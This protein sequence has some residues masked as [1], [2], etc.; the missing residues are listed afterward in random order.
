MIT[1]GR[2]ASCVLTLDDPALSRTHCQF[3]VVQD[4]V[5]VRDLNSRNGTLLDGESVARARLEPGDVLTIGTTAIG[6]EGLEEVPEETLGRRTQAIWKEV[7]RTRD[8]PDAQDPRWKQLLPL[9][10]K[11]LAELDE[12]VVLA[13]IIDGA[14]DLVGAERG[15]LLLFSGDEVTVEVART[16]WRRDIDD[17][18]VEISRGIALAVRDAD[19]GVLI[20]DAGEDARVGG[21][22]SVADLSLRSV[23]CVPLRFEGHIGGVAY[24]DHRLRP[25]RFGETDLELMEAFADLAAVALVTSGRYRDVRRKKESLEEEVRLERARLAAARAA[26]DVRGRSLEER[27]RHEGIVARSESM[28]RLLVQCERVV[29]TELPVLLVGE[30]GTGRERLARILHAGGPRR[31]GAFVAVGCASLPEALAEVELFGHAEGA[32]TGASEARPGLFERA[33]EGT[34]FLDGVEDLGLGTQAALLRVLETGEAR[35]VGEDLAREVGA[36]IIATTRE[37]PDA[38]VRDGRLRADL[39]YRLAGIRL[40]TP[41]LADRAADLPL[42]LDD[43]LARHA[44]EITLAAELRRDLL[45]RPWP[46]NLIAFENEVRRLALFGPGEVTVSDL[47]ASDAQPEAVGSLKEATEALERRMIASALEEEDGNIS[48]SAERLGLSRVGLRNK[49]R[50]LGLGDPD[51]GV[52]TS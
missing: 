19:E 32:F 26:L 4:Q 23:I 30:A 38:L 45:T 1:V 27:W 14:I 48:R 15:F 35:R 7:P 20:E 28:R 6:F 52:E 43:L 36:R 40:A 11:L 34:L 49:I 25:H 33:A 13:R 29:P 50:R 2:A 12:D 3:E 46:G 16:D 17:P 31:E 39:L 8:V 24:L 37:D 42:L 22:R 21:F 41:S 18:E 44:P 47:R 51:G 5:W 9:T 10:G